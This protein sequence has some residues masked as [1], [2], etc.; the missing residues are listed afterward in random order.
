MS[1]QTL[2]RRPVPSGCSAGC[3]WRPWLLA[4]CTFAAVIV[5]AVFLHGSGRVPFNADQAVVGLMANDIRAGARPV[6]FLG[7][8][9]AGTLESHAVA[10]AFSLLG[11]SAAVQKAVVALAFALTAALLAAA[12][13]IWFGGRAGFGAAVYLV[14]GPAYL[15]YKGLTSDGHYGPVLLVGSAFFL[16]LAL[17]ARN[18]GAGSGIGPRT[19]L[20]GLI[21]G[22]GLWVSPLC[23]SF[24]LV[25]VLAFASSPLRRAL[26]PQDGLFAIAGLAVGSLPWWVRNLETGFASLSIPGAGPA[27]AGVLRARFISFLFDG[28]PLLLGPSA[29]QAE[30]P[31]RAW[32]TL[33]VATAALFV[34]AYG[35]RGAL[36]RGTH[37]PVKLGLIATCGLVTVSIG[38]ALVVQGQDEPHGLRHFGEPRTALPAYLGFA[39]L[40]GYAVS[41]LVRRPSFALGLVAAFVVAHVSGWVVMPRWKGLQNGE[42]GEVAE[43]LAGLR[44]SGI[45]GVYAP[46]WAAYPV[47]FFSG[48]EIIGSPF[49]SNSSVRRPGDRRRVD[50]DPSPGFLLW[51]PDR[52]RFDAYLEDGGFPFERTELGSL[53]LFARV[54]PRALPGLRACLC[55]PPVITAESIS[56]EAAEGPAIIEQG[57][58]IEYRLRVRN[59]RLSPWPPGVNVG[60]HWRDRSGR[61]V[62]R[63]GLRTSVEAGPHEGEAVDLRVRVS[64]DVPP[65][66]YE[67]V[68]DLVIE[69]ITWFEWKGVAP[70]ARSVEIVARE[71]GSVIP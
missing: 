52:D 25:S 8:E 24:L 27:D 53:T 23:V 35:A 1:E 59:R 71:G 63:T 13:E 17:V 30:R 39:P 65:G 20:L 28:L 29:I 15:L 5:V 14:L 18:A 69:G 19:F 42:P 33:L 37:P 48:G 60:Y 47:S 61:D 6:F 40:V 46:Y 54:D 64:A 12:T 11:P 62:E 67:L 56:W 21:L 43:V 2:D 4:G 70:V 45:E 58:I 44:R 66:K 31:A 51:P 7:S 10:L 26:H 50:E 41:R 3:A 38:L 36:G 34:L 49:G 16:V 22:V 9:Y 32:A 57:T 68:F 55:V